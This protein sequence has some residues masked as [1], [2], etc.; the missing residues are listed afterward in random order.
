M[1]KHVSGRDVRRQHK[2]FFAGEIVSEQLDS[3]HRHVANTENRFQEARWGL[4]LAAYLVV[5]FFLG[6]PGMLEGKLQSE[7]SNRIQSSFL[8]LIIIT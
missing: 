1:N 6:G 5:F 8:N 3:Q 7:S 2:P 4:I